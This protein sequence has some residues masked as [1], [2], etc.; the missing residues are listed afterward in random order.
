MTVQDALNEALASQPAGQYVYECV[1]LDHVT[2]ADPLYLI[3]GQEANIT[4]PVPGVG[5]VEFVATVMSLTYPGVTEDGPSPARLRISFQQVDDTG[6][7][8]PFLLP[9]LRDATAATDPIKVSMLFY[10]TL[11]LSGPGDIITGLELRH[12]TLSDTWVEG[13]LAYRDTA[14]QAFPLYAYDEEFYPTLQGN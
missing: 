9:F 6:E 2:W 5:S 8:E 13:E 4:L 3:A 7:A 14:T 10:T 1:I 11:D 12:V